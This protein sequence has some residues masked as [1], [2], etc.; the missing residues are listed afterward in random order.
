MDI[1]ELKQKAKLLIPV[2]PETV[3]NINVD[4]IV[5]NSLKGDFSKSVPRTV[6]VDILGNNSFN[7][8]LPAVVNKAWQTDFSVMKSI[9][10]PAGQRDQIF[11][12]DNEWKITR[13]DTIF[14]GTV[15]SGPFQVGE[16]ITGGTSASTGTVTV[17][18]STYVEYILTSATAFDNG[19]TITGGTS[20]A[21][22]T[23][24]NVT[25]EKLFLIND[26]P[27]PTDILRLTYTI[28]WV[29]ATLGIVP[30]GKEEALIVLCAANYAYTIARFYGQT[31]DAT[32]NADT[33]DYVDRS[34]KWN[35]IGDKLR[36]RYDKLIGGKNGVV[37]ASETGNWDTRLS[38][39]SN[40]LTHDNEFR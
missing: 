13:I 19:E 24:T 5:N 29:T 11:L 35:T 15:T 36:R 7:Y 26:T 14:H 34:D 12:K 27:G 3:G 8:A 2:D 20:G 39:N 4:E 38:H 10:F 31:G 1:N 32:I 9:E 23:T 21:S 18:E 25:D 22:A 6:T 28:Q 33:V 17:V 30:A 40:Y 37:P 16:T